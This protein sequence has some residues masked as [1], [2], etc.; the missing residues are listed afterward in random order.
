MSLHEFSV[1]KYM[2]V[3][4]STFESNATVLHTYIVLLE[5]YDHS[6]L[7]FRPADLQAFCQEAGLLPTQC[8]VA[9]VE[10]RAP[11]FTVLSLVASK[12]KAKG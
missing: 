7:G 11:H 3:V 1:S 12:A 8:S 5:P 6:N 2:V 10:K 9:A 4:R